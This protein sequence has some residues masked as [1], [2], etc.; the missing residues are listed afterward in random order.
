MSDC[1]VCGVDGSSVSRRAASVAARLA[2]DLDSPALLVNVR[3]A[4]S[5]LGVRLPAL[6]GPRRRRRMLHSMAEEHG[7]PSRTKLRLRAGDPAGQLLA[8]AERSD[9]ELVVVGVRGPDVVVHDFL[10]SVPSTLMERA[11]CPVVIVPATAVAPFDAASMRSVV[12]GVGGNEMD[13]AVLRLA[14][15]IAR[16]LGGEL[17]AVHAYEEATL[18]ADVRGPQRKLNELLEEAGVEAHGVVLPA[19]APEAL[20]RVARQE[21]AGLI[22][23]GSRRRGRLDSVPHGSV[24]TRLAT[25]GSIPVVVLPPGVRLDRGGHYELAGA[26]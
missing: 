5:I 15:D 6:G 19:R 4:R 10:G 11:P 7:F 14:G 21:S 12:C 23:V 3:A 8:F 22:V 25:E 24:P 26:A 20:D 9:A 17:H 16:R 2:R 18:P 13:V 1:I